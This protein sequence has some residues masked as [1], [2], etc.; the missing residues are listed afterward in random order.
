MDTTVAQTALVAWLRGAGFLD[1]RVYVSEQDG[2]NPDELGNDAYATI[3]LRSFASPGS[4]VIRID[5]S[6]DEDPPDAGEEIEY[7]V[8]SHGVVLVSVQAYTPTTVGNSSALALVRAA[9]ARLALPSVHRALSAAGLSL[10]T[11]G[12]VLDVSTRLDTRWRGRASMELRFNALDDVSERVGYIGA[13]EGTVGLDD[14][15]PTPFSVT[16]P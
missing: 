6:E 15:T 14:D 5:H 12:D 1:Q 7:R 4:E 13:V 8:Q 10:A 11:A 3:K 9:R 2:F 16:I